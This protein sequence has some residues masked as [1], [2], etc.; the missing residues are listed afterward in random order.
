LRIETLQLKHYRNYPQLQIELDPNLNLFTG[1][2]AQGKTNLL[3][4]MFFLGTGR[5][6]RTRNES[7]LVHWGEQECTVNGNVIWRLGR[8]KMGVQFSVESKKKIFKEGGAQVERR[9]YAG[10]LIPVLFTPEDLMLVK[11]APQGRRR[12]FDEEISKMSPLYEAELARYHQI[13]RQ[14]NF[15]LKKHRETI[16]NTPEMESW[17]EQLARQGAAVLQKRMNAIHRIGLLARLTH[18][19]MTGRDENLEIFYCSTVPVKEPNKREMIYQAFLSALEEKKEEEARFGQTL[20]GPHRDDAIFYINGKNARIYGS[21]GQQ[22]T[23][24][25][26]L[27]LAEVEYVKGETGENPILLFDDVFSELDGQRR[28]LLV[29]SIDG[30]V[31]TFITGTEAEKLGTFK[32]SGRMFTVSNG[33]VN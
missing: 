20:V 1:A 26:A 28:G 7:E 8:Q 3:E 25:L 15:L 27:K 16:M 17:N 9:N 21:Q 6:F 14:R 18:R 30:R 19:N 2:N 23:L 10:K 13:L 5:S 12:F 24:I 31:Q 11:G 33:K 32:Q 4:A 29:E 22:R